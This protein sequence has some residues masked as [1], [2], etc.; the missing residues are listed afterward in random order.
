MNFAIDMIFAFGLDL[1]LGDPEWFPHPVRFIGSMI[2]HLEKTTRRL[3]SNARVAGTITG[4]L[5][6]VISGLLV[7]ATIK[8]ANLADPVLG[9]IVGILWLYLGLSARNLADSAQKISDDLER[10]DLPAARKSLSCIVGRDTKNLNESEISRG[11]V[12]SVSENTVD[13]IL[14]PIFFAFIGS[15]I[16]FCAAPMMWAFKAMS[17]CDSMIGHKDEQY[18]RFGTFSA[19]LDDVANYIPARLCYI[20][21][22]LA[23][24]LLGF[25]PS[26]CLLV[27]LRDSKYHDSPNAGIPE[28]AT[29]GALEI[30]LGGTTYYDGL[31][32]EKKPFGGEFLSPG[33]LHV[34]RTIRLM[35]MTTVLMLAAAIAIR[36]LFR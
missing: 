17:T 13:G 7:Y 35:W 5:T 21:F 32:H 24:F 12:E 3:F 9:R 27:A 26:K 25:S 1:M 19:R 10:G 14:T 23:S 29:A 20:L 16:P 4:L 31:P 30:K 11:A 36:M 33:K 18:I 6:V 15:F 2:N 34:L 28:A 22:P 8:L